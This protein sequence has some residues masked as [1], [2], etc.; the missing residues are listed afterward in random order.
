MKKS[1]IGICISLLC[2][3]TGAYAN[4]QNNAST[5]VVSTVTKQTKDSKADTNESKTKASK[6]EETEKL[7]EVGNATNSEIEQKTDAASK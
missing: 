3:G 2:V 1:V 6:H 7:E 5:P 4:Q